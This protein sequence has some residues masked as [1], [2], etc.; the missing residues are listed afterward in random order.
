MF[1]CISC[2]VYIS[3]QAYLFVGALCPEVHI[4]SIHTLTVTAPGC[5]IHLKWIIL[6]V[7]CYILFCICCMSYFVL[8]T[9]TPSILCLRLRL[10]NQS[11]PRCRMT[12][13]APMC[14]SPWR[15]CERIHNAKQDNISVYVKYYWFSLQCC[16][17]FTLLF[18]TNCCIHR[19]QPFNFFLF[20]LCPT[21]TVALRQMR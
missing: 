20:F 8:A 12:P 13:E 15:Q 11:D 5:Y 14:L 17:L 4:Q 2:T 6:A 7:S 10:C 21:Q 16:Q 9:Q 1:P 19:W 3:R 18:N